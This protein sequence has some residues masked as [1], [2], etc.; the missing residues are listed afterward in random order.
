MSYSLAHMARKTTT[1][2]KA[3]LQKQFGIPGGPGGV[4]Q[5]RKVKLGPPV[6]TDDMLR[7]PT[8]ELDPRNQIDEDEEEE[9]A[10][11]KKGAPVISKK[12]KSIVSGE[13]KIRPQ[14]PKFPGRQ[15]IEPPSDQYT[16]GRRRAPSSEKTF[17]DSME[18]LKRS[19]AAAKV[20]AERKGKKEKYVAPPIEDIV[21][22]EVNPFTKADVEFAIAETVKIA[23]ATEEEMKDFP[24]YEKQTQAQKDVQDRGAEEF[25]K[26]LAYAKGMQQSVSLEM[27]RLQKGLDRIEADQEAME[28]CDTSFFDQDQAD[29]YND[30]ADSL[31]DEKKKIEDEMDRIQGAAMKK[32]TQAKRATPRTKSRRV[33]KRR[34]STSTSKPRRRKTTSSG[35]RSPGSP[36]RSR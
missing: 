23:D 24:A 34:P 13:T 2:T 26:A 35:R 11:K 15:T 5:K 14:D 20:F 9:P 10:P 32:R 12:G 25:Q 31:R 6:A 29:Y 17:V 3:A 30:Y 16:L 21:G 4:P 19:S 18:G 8:D 28:M 7:D 22:D 1:M 33:V 36:A 27:A